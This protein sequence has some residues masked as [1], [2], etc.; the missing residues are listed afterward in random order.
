MKLDAIDGFVGGQGL[1]GSDCRQHGDHCEYDGTVLV[2]M[3]PGD[4]CWAGDSMAGAD[5]GSICLVR[6][7]G[8]H[9]EGNVVG[10]GGDPELG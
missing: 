8:G 10:V 9:V 7:V 2:S 4:S 3:S 5:V 6:S 1:D